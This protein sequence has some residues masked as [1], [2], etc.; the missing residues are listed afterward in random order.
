MTSKTPDEVARE[1]DAAVGGA[2]TMPDGRQFWID[3]PVAREIAA[4]ALKP[5]D[6][7]LTAE[8]EARE[9]AEARAKTE[10]QI[11]E[12][13]ELRVTQHEHFIE[14]QRQ[15]ISYLIRDG[16]GEIGKREKA[17]AER[18]EAKDEGATFVLEALADALNLKS[19]TPSDGTETWDGDVSGTLYTILRDARVMDPETDEL[20]MARAD[21]IRAA[22]TPSV[23]T[24]AAY[25]GEFKFSIS[26]TYLDEEA[27]EYRETHREVV[28][29][30]DTVKQIMT[31]IRA[32]GD[33][34]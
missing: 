30:W 9:K 26:E 33:K 14:E 15:R 24:K 27:L 6:A 23:E 19:Y 28:V 13:V 21:R 32:L 11:A 8:R 29:P 5:V 7:A 2:Y 34:P 12:A 18:D 17:E 22:L 16:L 4:R 3:G 1:I 10:R 20:A 25:M 31:A